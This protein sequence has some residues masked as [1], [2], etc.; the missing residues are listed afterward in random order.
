MVL[1]FTSSERLPDRSGPSDRLSLWPAGFSAVESRRWPFC[2][3]ISASQSADHLRT[4]ALEPRPGLNCNPAPSLLCALR[5]V[6]SPLWTYVKRRLQ[7]NLSGLSA[8]CRSN[9]WC[10]EIRW[11]HLGVHSSGDNTTLS[12]RP[13]L[14][15]FSVTPR[16]SRGGSR[17][18]CTKHTGE[19][20]TQRGHTVGIW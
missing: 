8:P 6:A 9:A 15:T 1:P 19:E 20:A 2:V 7:T 12:P 18:C 10:V 3:T 14:S 11:G 17:I 5:Q 16:G 13:S 4:N